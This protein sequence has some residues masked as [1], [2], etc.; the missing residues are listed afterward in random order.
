LKRR[1]RLRLEATAIWVAPIEYVILRKLDYYRMSGS[2]R[3]LRDVAS[4]LRISGGMV[5]SRNWTPGSSASTLHDQLRAA[6]NFP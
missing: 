5:D 6:R 3:H 1:S 2:D 4:M